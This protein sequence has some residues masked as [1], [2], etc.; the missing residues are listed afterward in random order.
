MQ[1]QIIISYHDK[2]IV[3]CRANAFCSVLSM[4]RNGLQGAPTSIEAD[5]QCF[6]KKYKLHHIHV[7]IRCLSLL[8]KLT[9]LL[10]SFDFVKLYHR[11]EMDKSESA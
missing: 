1:R 9:K 5:I 10:L 2:W 4:Q 7:A 11:S 8:L 6:K 3:T